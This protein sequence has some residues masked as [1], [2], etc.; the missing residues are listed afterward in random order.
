M[1]IV[2]KVKI[3]ILNLAVI[4]FKI[5]DDCNVIEIKFWTRTREQGP[6]SETLITFDNDVN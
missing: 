1:Q 4:S 3:D 5:K 2:L 6:P